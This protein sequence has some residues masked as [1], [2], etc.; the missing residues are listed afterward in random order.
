MKDLNFFSSYSKKADKKRVDNYIVLY[1]LLILLVAG[2]LIYGI[3]NFITISRLNNDIAYKKHELNT[4]LEDPKVKKIMGK[5]ED[6][7]VLK[8]DIQKLNTLEKYVKD[9]DV[10]D[11]V[12]LEDIR[13]NIPSLVFIDSMTIS[14]QNIKVEGKSKDKES[15]AQFQHNLNILDKFEQVFIP[16]ILDGDG[17]Y[18][19][20]LDFK[21][22]EGEV[23]GIEAE[24]QQ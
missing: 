8:E 12:L 17:H 14:K 9:M 3:Y 7:E 22:K 15:I 21:L 24:K 4:K 2:I 5:E 6:I 13:D 16:E 19:F 23:N 18:N 11:E 20:Y 1:T 10:I